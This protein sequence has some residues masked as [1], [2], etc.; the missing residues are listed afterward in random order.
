[1]QTYLNKK[2]RMQTYMSTN[3]FNTSPKAYI[4]NIIAE[5]FAL[6][7]VTMDAYGLFRKQGQHVS[8][9]VL[10]L[11]FKIDTAA[12]RDARRGITQ[13]LL[14]D[15]FHAYI[16]HMNENKY[17]EL[18]KEVAF[19]ASCVGA[20]REAIRDFL[21]ALKGVALPE[22]MAIIEHFIWQVKRKLNG[23]SV[24]YH[25][26]PIITGPQGTGKS[27]LLELFLEPMKAVLLQG[28][29]VDFVTDEKN[30]KALSENFIIFFD[31]MAKASRTDADRLKEIISAQ[32]I[33]YR[34][35]YTNENAKTVQN[36]TFIGAANKDVRDLLYDPTGMRRFYQIQVNPLITREEIL[37]RWEI[38]PKINVL[39]MW[40]CVDE[41]VDVPTE[42]LKYLDVIGEQQKLIKAQ[43]S[44]E[45][46]IEDTGLIICEGS[47]VTL[48]QLY[49]DYIDYCNESG[50]RDPVQR[51]TF[52]RELVGKGFEKARKAQGVV[53]NVRYSNKSAKSG[54]KVIEMVGNS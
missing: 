50:R 14:L 39:A 28:R 38:V 5:W 45:E 49:R 20:G 44:V 32:I 41:N 12:I 19:D 7:G 24:A 2:K 51:V 29:P 11:D 25:L 10:R 35:L 34:P 43:T 54:V 18:K 15:G 21:I 17:E 40:R 42:Y 26:M 52:S 9:E 27:T 33:S 6:Q 13:E 48:Q 30:F 4:N 47:D 16:R 37:E 3:I 1:M 22:E 8:Y 31:E 46:F 36:C 53:F 23:K